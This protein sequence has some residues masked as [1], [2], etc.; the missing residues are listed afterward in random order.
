[1]SIIDQTR[2][3]ERLQFFN[4]QRLFAD[5]LQGLEAFNREMR[6]LHN[7]SLHQPGVGNGFAV[8]GKKGDREVTVGAGYAIDALGREIVLT[9]TQI[10]PIPPVAGDEQGN[11]IFFDL[12]VSYPD[13]S[14]LEEA[15][16]RDGVC[17]PRG[18]VRLREAPVFCWVE[19]AGDNLIPKKPRL[20]KDIQDNLKIRLARIEALNCQLNSPVSTDQR[21]NA[22]PSG[23]PYISGGT[24]KVTGLSE[25]T[26]LSNLFGSLLNG[27][28]RTITAT[29]NTEQAGFL[30]TPEYTAH[31]T[32]PREFTVTDP[33]T[34]ATVDVLVL[35]QTQIVEATLDHFVIFTL[36]IIAPIAGSSLPSGVVAGLED[37]IRAG[38]RIVWMGVEG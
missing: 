32:G 24:E 12:T 18:V 5:D 16:T 2:F 15:E 6:W 8:N 21:L 33:T 34:G 22:R 7:Q 20:R 37:Q 35:D 38:W 29:I 31:I 36:L 4:G 13:D 1:V 25:S 11:P 3:I 26:A 28:V 23:N 27:Q 9:E 30:T 17:A 10:L 19:L 14:A